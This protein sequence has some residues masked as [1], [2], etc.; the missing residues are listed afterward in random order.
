MRAFIVA[1][2]AALLLVGCATQPTDTSTPKPILPGV[3][4]PP[5]PGDLI[6]TPPKKTLTVM[7]MS[8]KLASLKSPQMRM[9]A[10]A[11][12]AVPALVYT[13]DMTNVLTIRLVYTNSVVFTNMNRTNSTL[14]WK[15]NQV[16]TGQF[17]VSY[18]TNAWEYA[19]VWSSNAAEGVWRSVSLATN[20]PSRATNDQWFE[21][22]LP[23]RVS[24]NRFFQLA[25]VYTVGILWNYP[26]ES[27]TNISFRTYTGSSSRSYTSVTNTTWAASYLGV[28][29][30]APNI[31]DALF[32]TWISG[33]VVGQ[34]TYLAMTAVDTD[35]LES[36]FSLEL[37]IPSQNH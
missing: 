22:T 10:A 5:M 20:L 29:T 17:I 32:G 3:L 12:E 36:D 24:D 19:L 26:F 9:K 16:P 31:G 37:F 35:G 15:T 34:P 6:P 21:H 13:P 7:A 23:L 11:I 8:P 14:V 1:I 33:L 2:L 28:E 18:P 30:N 25:K 4:L 27:G